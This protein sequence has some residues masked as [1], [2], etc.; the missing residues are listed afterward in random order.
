MEW[1]KR[2]RLDLLRSVKNRRI[3]VRRHAESV[4]PKSKWAPVAHHAQA[5]GA[6][7]LPRQGEGVVEASFVELPAKL[8]CTLL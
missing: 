2:N 7:L 4:T 3:L 5:T 6:F 1:S 8:R